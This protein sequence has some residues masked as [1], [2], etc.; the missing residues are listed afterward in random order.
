MFLSLRF[1]LPI[2]NLLLALVVVVVAGR[3]VLQITK[4]K[5]K[6]IV[7][8]R[9]V[10]SDV[11]RPLVLILTATTPDYLRFGGRLF[12]S[13]HTNHTDLGFSMA[14]QQLTRHTCVFAN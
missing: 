14:S 8:P 10:V 13:Y 5:Q 3:C 1:S 12:R 9:S 11:F 2:R 6:I 4:Q 7:A